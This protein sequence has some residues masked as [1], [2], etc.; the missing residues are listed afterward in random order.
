MSKCYP[1]PGTLLG[2]EAVEGQLSF[3][4]ITKEDKELVSQMAAFVEGH[5]NSHFLQMPQWAGVKDAWRW[6]G[7]L[8]YLDDTIIGALSV[9]IRP[10]P[11]HMCIMY[12]PRGPV[13]DRN[14]PMV[15][16]LLQ[17]G[18]KALA[19]DQGALLLMMDTDEPDTNEDFRKTMQKL[20]Y[21]ESADEGFD[22]ACAGPRQFL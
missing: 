16:S 6:R 4:I 3:Q 7:I 20:G 15:L 8:A 17:A 9:L 21:E 5:K 18:A 12:A 2:A 19:K 14:D 1:K 10:M 22:N 13:C 11:L